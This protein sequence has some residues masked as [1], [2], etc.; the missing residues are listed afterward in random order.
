MRRPRSRQRHAQAGS[1]GSAITVEA[2]GNISAP[3]ALLSEVFPSYAAV[4]ACQSGARTP[5]IRKRGEAV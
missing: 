2:I 1:A 3:D 4:D 5:R